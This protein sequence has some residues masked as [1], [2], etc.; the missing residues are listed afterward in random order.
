MS[1]STTSSPRNSGVAAWT[2]WRSRESDRIGLLVRS[3]ATFV[4]GKQDD[5]LLDSCMYLPPT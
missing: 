1:T 5:W 3:L 2:P 4:S